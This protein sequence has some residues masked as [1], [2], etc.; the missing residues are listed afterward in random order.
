MMDIKFYIS[1]FFRRLHYFLIMLT[2]GS[3]IGVTL[4]WMLP[5]V[6]RAEARLVVESAQ[7]PGNLAASTVLIEAREQ[8]QIIQQRI[9]TRDTLLEMANRLQ[10]YGPAGQ[11]PRMAADQIVEDLRGRLVIATTGGTA[12]Q[13]TLVSVGFKAP[14]AALSATVANELVTLILQE[15]IEMR[16]SVAGQTLD[17]F[18]QEVA[19]LDKRLADQSA[20]ILAF[21]EKNGA[22]LPD[23]LEFRRGQQAAA[24]ER[25]LQVERDESLL[26]DRRDGLIALYEATGRVGTAGEVPQTEEERQLKALRD[27]LSSVLAVLSPENP[28]AKMLQSQVS[29]LEKVVAAQRAATAP[30]TPDGEALSPLEIQLADLDRQLQFLADRKTQIEAE[31]EGLRVSIEATP[32]N[33]IV[34]DTMERDYANTRAQYDEAVTNKARAETGDTIEALSKGQRIT[35]IEQAVAPREPTSP[36]RPL[37]VAAGVGAGFA[38]GL[39]LVV[40]IEVLKGAIRRPADITAKLGITAFATLPYLRTAAEIRRRRALIGLA[41]AVVILA[42]PAGLWGLH[43]QV[44]PLDLLFDRVMQKFGVA[45]F[46]ATQPVSA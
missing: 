16:T 43:T 9:L 24:Q 35:V 12:G 1:L 32:S 7:I 38:L 39:G 6:Y 44:M 33:A 30:P 13:V 29:N 18:V 19:Q 5:P 28:K 41:F 26:K 23:S 21:K 36:N 10:I 20:S 15:N 27:Q 3:V 42:I 8:L 45:G 40:L 34:L 37:V 14:T 2:L 22:A 4:A 25:L 11:A 17:F 31:L 46:L